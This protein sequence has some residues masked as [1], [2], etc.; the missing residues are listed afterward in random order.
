[1][2]DN[3]RSATQAGHHPRRHERKPALVII[4]R[5]EGDRFLA[6]LASIGDDVSRVIYVD[7][8]STDGSVAA[9]EAAGVE[10]VHLDMRQPFTAARAR[11]AGLERLNDGAPPPE[12]VQFIDGDCILQPDWIRSAADFL[13]DRPDVAMVC[14]RLRERFPEATIYNRLADLEWAGPPGETKACGG[15][16]MGRMQALLQAGG[17]NPALIAGE[18]PE[19]CLRLRMAGWTIWRLGDDMALHDAAMT[20]FGQW[21]QRARR[22]GYTYAEG[23]AMHGRTPERHKR[24]ELTSVLVRGLVLPLLILLGTVFLTPWMLLGLLIYPLQTL[25]LRLGGAPWDQA[26]FLTLIRFPEA[27]GALTYVWR[28]LTRKDARLIEY[29]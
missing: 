24:R 3:H 21:W 14:G 23:V 7:S 18:E 27:Q 19:L 10:V 12:F 5:N 29:K 22:A 17:F 20:R 28:R 26:W 6:C 9:A 25:R 11:N 2:A 16:A 1:M 15:I 4:G 8:G 13:R